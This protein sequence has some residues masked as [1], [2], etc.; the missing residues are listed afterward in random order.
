MSDNEV[1]DWMTVAEAAAYLNLSYRTTLRAV[2][3]GTIPSITFGPRTTRIPRK[4]L[5]AL[6]EDPAG[7][8]LGTRFGLAGG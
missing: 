1:K 5:L 8:P 2:H 3:A 7:V 6:A 4:A